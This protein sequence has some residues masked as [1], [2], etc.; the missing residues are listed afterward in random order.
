MVGEVIVMLPGS[1]IHSTDRACVRFRLVKLDTLELQIS[2]EPSLLTRG[3][4]YYSSFSSYEITN[5]VRAYHGKTS[6]ISSLGFQLGPNRGNQSPQI[7][8]PALQDVNGDATPG[9]RQGC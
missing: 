5:F 7:T 9:R 2:E 4:T 8:F 1:L 6:D 3:E